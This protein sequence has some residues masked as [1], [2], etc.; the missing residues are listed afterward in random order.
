MHITE[1]STLELSDVTKRFGSRV[2]LD[3]LNLI[4]PRGAIVGLVGPNGAGKSTALRIAAGLTRPDAGRATILGSPQPTIAARA[5]CAFVPDDP[6]GL[7]DLSVGAVLALSAGLYG[8]GSAHLARAL[9]LL[10]ALGLGGHVRTPMGALS[11][12]S[13]RLVALVAGLSARTPFL[14]VDEAT[15]ALDPRAVVLLRRALVTIAGAGSGVL[16]ASQSLDFAA[17]ACN[18]VVL[19]HEGA[20]VAMGSPSELLRVHDCQSLEDVFVKLVFSEE[21]GARVDALLASD[22]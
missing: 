2:V 9:D 3:G 14:I 1:S 5:S 15:A 4:V 12:G 22:R 11:H 18:V 16:L 19:L 8:G 20:P 6:T 7:D 21:A 17:R 13:R 10:D